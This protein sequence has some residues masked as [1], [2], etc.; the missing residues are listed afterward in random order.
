MVW[1]TG[2]ES[3]LCQNED[4]EFGIWSVNSFQKSVLTT[5]NKSM[6]NF[7]NLQCLFD[8]YYLKEI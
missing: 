3:C 6:Y 7:E 1:S 8:T 4:K 2:Q 5:D